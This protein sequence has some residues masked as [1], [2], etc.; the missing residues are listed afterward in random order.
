MDLTLPPLA[1]LGAYGVLILGASL[2]GGWL[3]MLLRPTHTRLQLATSF[4]AG[5]MLGVGLLHML[6]HAWHQVRSID[7]VAAWLLGGFLVVFL[8]QRFLHF[9]HHDVPEK[10]SETA[11]ACG[12]DHNHDHTADHLTE[13]SDAACRHSLAEQS[14]RRLSWAGASVGLCLHS[15][16]DGVAVAASVQAESHGHDAGLLTAIGTFLVVFLHKPFDA[17]AVGVLMA[18]GEHSR[19]LRHLINGLLALAVPLGMVLFHLG[20]AQAGSAEVFLGAAL[21]FSGG[22][23][24]CIAASDLLPE[25]QFHAHDRW[26]LSFALVAGLTLSVLIG[27]FERTGHDRSSGVEHAEPAH[28]HEH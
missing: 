28:T 16:L 26:K 12:S 7:R 5:L 15:I 6:P 27:A 11:C 21:A 24:L 22:T 17:M 1:L 3:P 4:V 23:F 13:D 25:L 9:H 20:L 2:A 19:S 14:A 18:R 8:L 10:V